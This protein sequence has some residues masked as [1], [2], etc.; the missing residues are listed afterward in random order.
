MIGLASRVVSERKRSHWAWGWE[1]K[2]PSEERRREI[3]SQLGALFAAEGASA[4]APVLAPLPSIDDARLPEPRVAVPRELASIAS[5]TRVDRTA[6]TYGRA[7]KD[8]LRAYRGDFAVAPDFVVYAKSEDDVARAIAWC[9]AER[10]ALVPFGGG[11]SVVGGVE[12]IAHGHRGVVSLDLRALDRVLAIDTASRAARIQAGA[13]GPV[14][15]EQLAAHG[16]SLRHYPQSFE[17]ATLGGWIATRAGGHFATLYTHI[18]DLV[19]SVRMVGPRG[20]LETKRFPASGAGPA[21]E[22]LV[23]GSEGILGVIT[24]AW[25]RVQSRPRWRSSASVFFDDLFAAARGARAIA[26]AALFPANC[27]VLDAREA[28][29]NGVPTDGGAVLLLGFESA[30]RPMEAPMAR[31]IELAVASGGRCPRGAKHRDDGARGGDLSGEAWRQAFFDGPYLQSAL[32]T[33]GFIADTFETACTWDRFEALY[34]AIAG[35]TTDAMK[36]VCGAGSL[37]CRLTHV[38]PDGPAPYFTFIAPGRAGA[39]L[40]QWNEIKRAASD[41]LSANGATITHHHAV[42]RMHRPWYDRERPDLFADALR[43]A[44]RA[45]DPN[46]ILNPGVLID[47]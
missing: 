16:L 29:V 47:P 26:Q 11:T 6:H 9:D 31:A 17:F 18:D 40:E 33:M 13:T 20:V 5:A 42:G 21:P 25:V 3:A 8:V 14:L 43:A 46:A 10:V 1:D 24:E 4:A 7:Y 19:E 41:A 30:D 27:R 35:A 34:A 32:V 22:R 39:E 45:L 15:E 2:L 44:K 38:Y 28:L 37:S 23:L 36:R 12:G